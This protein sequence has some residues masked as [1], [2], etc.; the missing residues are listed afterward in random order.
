M[1]DAQPSDGVHAPRAWGRLLGVFAAVFALFQGAATA[2]GSQRGEA[3]LAIGALVVL[4]VVVAERGLLGA[5]LAARSLDA[6]R[7]AGLLAA[8]GI[9]LALLAVVPAVASLS[10]GAAVARPGWPALL[11]GLFAQAGV[12]EELLFRGL[13]FAHLR[14]GRT[15][16]RAVL[17]A[18]G[19]CVLAHLYLF[20]TLP[21]AL[22]AASVALS[23]VIAVPLAR[24]FELGGG[25]IWAPALVHAVVQG[26]LKLVEVEGVPAL[27]LAWMAASA[28][29]PFLAFAAR[30]PRDPTPPARTW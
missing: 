4:A 30:G 27:P 25:T 19:P 3:G 15:F 12:A 26:T 23:A 21:W 7:R 9:S 6:P 8:L 2:A 22:A 10:G 17:L 5:P 16:R 28:T 29:I 13:L 1:T 14:R 24:L 18:T 20:A 11:P